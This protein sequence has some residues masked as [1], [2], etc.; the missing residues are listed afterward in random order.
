MR[1]TIGR[2]EEESGRGAGAGVCVGGTVGRYGIKE[3]DA[4]NT[5]THNVCTVPGTT[6]HTYG[7]VSS[8]LQICK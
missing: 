8:F 5:I 1:T 3:C 2:Q 7:T 6:G 4:T